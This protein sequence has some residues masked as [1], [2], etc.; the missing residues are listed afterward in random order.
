LISNTE[1]V[2]FDKIFDSQ[3]TQITH[4]NE[5]IRDMPTTSSQVFIIKPINISQ[6]IPLLLESAGLPSRIKHAKKILIKPNIVDAIP[7]PVTTPCDI[8]EAVAEYL[9]SITSS[10]IIIGD[11][12]GSTE[13]DTFYPFE[14]LGYTKMAA[15]K[16]IKLADLNTAPYTKLTSPK[17]K[18]WPVM[19]LP[20]IIMESFIISIPVLKAHTLAGVTLTMKNMMGA[21]PPEHY[22]R[23]G[24]WNKSAFHSA[25]H[26]SIADLNRYRTPDFT[27][28]DARRGMAE[29]HLYGRECD[30]PPGIVAASSDPVAIDAYG[31]CLLGKDWRQIKYINLVNG[32]LGDAERMQLGKI[33]RPNQT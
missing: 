27:I 17:C 31:T 20:D 33:K 23:G 24:V 32:E 22:R 28:L 12:T 13:Y 7:P 30:P 10:D 2:F 25:I 1:I 14:K 16:N 8:V 26:E 18:Q 21:L 19:F 9:L 29:A 5:T 6:D 4:Y 3:K 11:G 15:Q